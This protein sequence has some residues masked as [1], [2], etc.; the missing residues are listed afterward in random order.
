MR[1]ARPHDTHVVRRLREICERE[2]L[3]ADA[4]AL[5]TLVGVAQGDFRG[6]LNTLQMLKARM[7]SGA[8][9]GGMVTEG[10]VRSAT[11]GMKEAEVGMMTVLGDLFA[12]LS[13]RRAKE[14]GVREDEPRFVTRLSM[15]VESCDSLDKIA[16]GGPRFLTLRSLSS[17]VMVLM[18]GVLNRVLR[19]LCPAA[20]A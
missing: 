4:R 10:V 6:C 1:F 7:D 9:G 14:M 12:P 13:K 20:S 18:E 3:K 16:I 15:A 2:G 19:A 5:A 8:T 17:M 11:R